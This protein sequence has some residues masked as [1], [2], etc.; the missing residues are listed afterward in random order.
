MPGLFIQPATP[1][2]RPRGL[3]LQSGTVT[4]FNGDAL[5]T[6]KTLP[7]NYFQCCV[8]SPPYYG[9]RDYQT[10]STLEIGREPTLFEY[11]DNLV[12]VFRE[13]WRVMRDDGICF[14]N[15]G[16]SYANSG[17]G[18]GSGIQLGNVGS[19]TVKNRRTP[20]FKHKDLLMVP[21]R[22][23]I[24]LQDDGWYIRKDI[25]WNKLNPMP[26][27]ATDRPTS[28]HEHVIMATKH[29]DYFYDAGAVE[30]PATYGSD[31]GILRTKKF[32][33]VSKS[34][35]KAS[36]EQRGNIDSRNGNPE[37]M[38]NL[39]D[40]W[41]F[42]TETSTDEHFAVMPQRMAELCIKA[43]SS[44]KGCCRVCRAPWEL[45]KEIVG[46]SRGANQTIIPDRLDL[47]TMQM[48]RNVYSYGD[49][50]PTCKC[51]DF[52]P[53]PCA[54]LDPFGGISTTGLVAAKLGR[55]ATVIELGT[56]YIEIMKTR[57]KREDIAYVEETRK[58]RVPTRMIIR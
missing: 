20:G 43:G 48:E 24:A 34:A 38:R 33:P 54:I 46:N 53:T 32:D 2:L 45:K 35:Q 47:N 7:P 16:D 14:I 1:A 37:G 19:G 55:H 6:L 44:E 29:Y 50:A 57:L 9:L 11:I 3:F 22:V 28:S 23:A 17:G 27:S 49:W 8:T 26:E 13:V 31:L 30:E 10:G 40:V 36:V 4:I 56:Q 58:P 15:L 25:I 39:R 52:E 5:N 21:A 12:L 51:P 18:I 42:A 41:T